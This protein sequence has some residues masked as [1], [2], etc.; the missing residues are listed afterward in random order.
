MHNIT[1]PVVLDAT[2]I[3]GGLSPFNDKEMIIGFRATGSV[4]RSDFGMGKYVP[5]VSDETRIVI[6]VAF[7]KTVSTNR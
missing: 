4:K 3:G 2:F 7:K 1:L 5:I 6:S